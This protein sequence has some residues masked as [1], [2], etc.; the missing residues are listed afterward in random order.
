MRCNPRAPVV[1]WVCI[2]DREVRLLRRC[3]RNC[4]GLRPRPMPLVPLRGW[5]GAAAGKPR[6]RRPPRTQLA[7]KSSE[8]GYRARCRRHTPW[9]VCRIPRRPLP[10]LTL[11]LG[12][13]RSGKS[14]YAESLLSAAN[15]RRCYL[16]TAGADDA[17]MESRILLHR[18]RRGP[19]WTTVEEPLDLAGVLAAQAVPGR[20]VLVD[21]LTLWLAN[22]MSAGRDC[23]GR[24]R[25]SRRG[26]A[27]AQGPGGDGRERGRPG[28]R[29][30][31]CSGAGR[32]AT[33]PGGSTSAWRS[34]ASA[35]CSSRPACRSC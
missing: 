24:D 26:S 8:G 2:R 29:A 11:V 33:M 20:A 32:S 16:A 23:R 31:Q 27:D 34:S 5:E 17:E 35:W 13:A 10:P 21:C 22:L 19:N 4:D 3:P 25:T 18:A 28:H 1:W 9:R 7:F 14:A 15:G 6:A 12:G 30:R